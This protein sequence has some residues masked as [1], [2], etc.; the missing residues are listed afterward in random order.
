MSNKVTELCQSTESIKEFAVEKL[1]EHSGW[2]VKNYSL[3]DYEKL[4]DFAPEMSLP[5]A[6]V[7]YHGSS[8]S[9]ESPRRSST[10]CVTVL[11][12][13]VGDVESAAIDATPLL[14]KAL[15][16]LDYETN[17][18]VLYRARSDEPLHYPQHGVAGH[19]I[20]FTVDDF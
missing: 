19:K 6:V 15:E 11:V 17:G 5:A 16:L 4:F 18:K 2:T 10:L 14:D 8:F 13:D 20:T 12:E 3:T 9:D 7:S 1:S